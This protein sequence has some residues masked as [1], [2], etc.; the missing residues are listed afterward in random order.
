MLNRYLA[1]GGLLSLLC[2]APAVAAP[3]TV[4]LRVEG[5]N[6]TVFE[7]PVTT[8][9]K[10]VTTSAGGSHRC[11][12]TN[13]G[14]PNAAGG[15]PTTA[16]DDAS[17]A[18]GFTWDGSYSTSFDD[19]L[20]EQIG[21][22]GGVGAP[23]TGSFW[24]IVVNR[25]GA[26]AGGCQ[27]RVNNGDQV[28]LEWADGTKPNLQLTA[29]AAAAAGT[30]VDVSVQQ[31]GSDGV[32]SAASGAAVARATTGADGH[33]AVTFSAPGVQHV[34]ATRSDAIRSND[35]D[36]CVYTPGSGDCGSAKAQSPTLT[37]DR[38]K[39]TAILKGI[40][41]GQRFRHGPRKLRGSASD[42]RGLFQVYFLLKRH[43]HAGCSWFSSKS[44]RFTRAKAHCSSA[45]YQRVGNKSSWSF[46]LPSALPAGRYEL[47]EKAIDS[48]YNGARQTIKFTVTG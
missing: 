4:N 33:A 28:L 2:A 35:V 20:I 14:T 47:V 7:G 30:P 45:R 25:V 38:V 43:S 37:P 13:G 24:N 19:F 16:L 39:P 9:G 41:N 34:K 1:L 31:Y 3:V 6:G 17:K 27:I 18:A 23:F 26:T 44:A 21:S 11:D 40:R 8:D 15:T 22:D 32:L 12:G 48:S 42:D 5:T 46:L 29:P 10:T 36:V